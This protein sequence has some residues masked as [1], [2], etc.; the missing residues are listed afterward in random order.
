MEKAAPWDVVKKAE[1]WPDQQQYVKC[2]L[3]Q[4]GWQAGKKRNAIR[5]HAWCVTI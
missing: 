2:V 5:Q 4:N 1:Y 3:A